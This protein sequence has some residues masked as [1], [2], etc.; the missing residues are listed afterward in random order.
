MKLVLWSIVGILGGILGGLVGMIFIYLFLFSFKDPAGE[1][2]RD[3]IKD[4][5]MIHM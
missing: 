3:A 1:L 5:F 2:V 4:F